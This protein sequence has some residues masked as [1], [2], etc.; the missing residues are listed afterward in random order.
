MYGTCVGMSVTT[1][2]ASGE[3]QETYPTFELLLLT[4]L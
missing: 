2:E 1:D 3:A 4:N